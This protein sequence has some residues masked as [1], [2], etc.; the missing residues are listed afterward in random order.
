MSEKTN[1]SDEMVASAGKMVSLHVRI[2]VEMMWEIDRETRVQNETMAKKYDHVNFVCFRS[3][4]DMVR[5]L[6]AEGMHSL[7]MTKGGAKWARCD[8]A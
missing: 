2:P 5:Y 1:I 7:F 6:L 4:S 8:G 3:R